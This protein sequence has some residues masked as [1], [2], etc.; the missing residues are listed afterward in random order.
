MN[1]IKKVKNFDKSNLE[2]IN[3]FKFE[4]LHSTT[5]TQKNKIIKNKFL[6]LYC[7]KII[8]VR[9]MIFVL[10]FLFFSTSIFAN[11]NFSNKKNIDSNQNTFVA[12]NIY[13]TTNTLDGENI[14]DYKPL[15]FNNLDDAINYGIQNSKELKLLKDFSIQNLKSNKLNLKQF[16]P[17]LSFLYSEYDYVK[18]YEK[19]SKNKNIEFSLN[20]LIFDNLSSI[21]SYKYNK[22]IALIKTIQ[23]NFQ[24]QEFILNIIEKYY[25][26]ILHSQTIELY[27][28]N[29]DNLLNEFKIIEYKYNN[30]LSLKDEYLEY[31]IQISEIKNSIKNF[32]IS[33]RL[34]YNQLLELLNLDY[35]TNLNITTS[36]D[37]LSFDTTEQYINEK[38]IIEST[39]E[40][41]IKLKELKENI[42]L[43]RLKI[44]NINRFYFPRV[45]LNSSINFSKE[46]FPLTQP[47]YSV[48]LTFN[49]NNIPFNKID[50]SNQDTFSNKKLT[51]MNN[52]IKNTLSIEPN[53]FANK[54]LQKLSLENSILELDKYINSIKSEMT[55]LITEHDN[56]LSQIN[57][58]LE[59][60]KLKEEKLI[61][62][63]YK[64]KNSLISTN[65]YFKE[66]LNYLDFIKKLYEVKINLIIIQKKILI[67]SGNF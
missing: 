63:E 65:D 32:E 37:A 25:S 29:L 50:F 57:T 39:L 67:K 4:K 31:Q 53:Y 22:K 2:I 1:N 13:D 21:T 45:Y 10:L 47:D 55:Q 51:S 35:D 56:Y 62:N 19:N 9:L 58:S 7:K 40:N 14:Y 26:Y 46:H 11:Q 24:E 27:K 23:Y 66:K 64:Y 3:F 18:K 59:L 43:E 5:T 61:I 48:S 42:E 28:K 60:Q 49:F 15:Q 44:K 36:F 6:Y 38:Y 52:S 17:E 41:D 20:Q 54:K 33:Q 8:S 30:G 12:E 16:L 34:I